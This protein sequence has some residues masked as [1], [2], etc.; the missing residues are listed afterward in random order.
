MKYFLF[1]HSLYYQGMHL[2]Y[3]INV[4]GQI[5]DDTIISPDKIAAREI[6]QRSNSENLLKYLNRLYQS[7]EESY[8]SG[9]PVGKFISDKITQLFLDFDKK[10]CIDFASDPYTH[11]WEIHLWEQDFI[12]IVELLSETGSNIAIFRSTLLRQVRVVVLRSKLSV[13]QDIPY[14]H[15]KFQLRI[16]SI[17]EKMP[18]EVNEDVLKSTINSVKRIVHFFSTQTNWTSPIPFIV[19]RIIEAEKLLMKKRDKLK[20]ISSY[21]DAVQFES[22]FKI[23]KALISYEEQLLLNH[24]STISKR[25]TITKRS[26]RKKSIDA[27]IVDSYD[28]EEVLKLLHRSIKNKCGKQVTMVI[29]A[30]FAAGLTTVERI[31]YSTVSTELAILELKPVTTNISITI[32][33]QSANA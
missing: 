16:E 4:N 12:S 15:D 22:D 26:P 20:G 18:T 7:Y 11:L 14:L 13:F 17:Y 27:Y 29:R 3:N 1:L 23:Y 21:K 31:P 33:F 25:N 2:F 32:T 10:C 30:A 8:T 5:I 24:F 9:S 28:K 19:Y 6:I